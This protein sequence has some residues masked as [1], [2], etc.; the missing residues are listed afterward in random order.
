M[1]LAVMSERCGSVAG[2]FGFD[3]VQARRCRSGI[4]SGERTGPLE[5]HVARVE[6]AEELLTRLCAV[7]AGLIGGDCV[8]ECLS[9][10]HDGLTGERTSR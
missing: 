5:I 10:L 9:L 1:A 3:S 4:R 6:E 2:R 8:A 7:E